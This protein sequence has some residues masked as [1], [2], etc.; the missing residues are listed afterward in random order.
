MLTLR[1]KIRRKLWVLLFTQCFCRFGVWR[2]RSFPEAPGP[3]PVS[4]TAPYCHRCRSTPFGLVTTVTGPWRDAHDLATEKEEFLFCWNKK[5]KKEE[6]KKMCCCFSEAWVA[7]VPDRSRISS[8][9]D[10]N[11]KHRHFT[12]TQTTHKPTAEHCAPWSKSTH[13]PAQ[14]LL[15][16]T[17]TAL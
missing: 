11:K 8:K 4:G 13:T 16:Q 5:I 12:N 3:G 17:E 14:I 7:L 15:D 2:V 6:Q 10:S 1:I 9:P